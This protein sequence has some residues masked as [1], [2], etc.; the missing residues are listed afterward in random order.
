MAEQYEM[1]RTWAAQALLHS[2]GGQGL[3]P[4]RSI[5]YIF[6]IKANG[7]SLTLLSC[8]AGRAVLNATHIDMPRNVHKTHRPLYHA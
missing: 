8:A 5:P 1:E 4:G 6:G 7:Q 3:I 2:S